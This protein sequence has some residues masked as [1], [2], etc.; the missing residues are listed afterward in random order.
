MDLPVPVIKQIISQALNFTILAFLLWKFLVP[1]FAEGISKKTKDI[2]QTLD[3]TAK[4]LADISVELDSVRK[5]LKEAEGE[6]DKIRVEAEQRGDA[7]AAKIKQDTENEIAALRSRVDRQIEQE[8]QNLQ[9]RL[10]QDIV[11]DVMVQAEALVREKSDAK[12]QNQLVTHFAHSL[13]DF[14]EYRS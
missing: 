11:K 10:R 6:I 7:A 8:F 9:N 2:N 13:K 4:N 5:E 12:L 1:K 14:K 3:E